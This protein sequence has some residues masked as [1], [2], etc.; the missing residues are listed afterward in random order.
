MAEQWKPTNPDFPELATKWTAFHFIENDKETGHMQEFP[1][2]RR[3][4]DY[5][6]C[7]VD[8]LMF[9]AVHPGT[10]LQPHRDM[11]ANLLVGKLRLHIPII[12][13]QQIEFVVDGQRLVMGEGELWALD[14][15]YVHSVYNPSDQIRIHCVVQVFANDW[16]WSLLPKKSILYYRHALCFWAVASFKGIEKL[17]KDPQFILRNIRAL[18][19]KPKA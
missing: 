12:T 13:N 16:V 11:S 14:T 18:V 2:V 8:E 17:V 15:S 3:V 10:K 6:K 1:E 9:Y 5:F 4:R 19:R 7:P